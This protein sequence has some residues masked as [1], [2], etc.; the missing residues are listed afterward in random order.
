MWHKIESQLTATPLNRGRAAF[1]SKACA[2]LWR[3]AS[4][5]RSPEIYHRSTN[6]TESEAKRTICWGGVRMRTAL[7]EDRFKLILSAYFTVLLEASL[8]SAA[9][10]SGCE[11]IWKTSSMSSKPMRSAS[12]EDKSPDLARTSSNG[13]HISLKF[14][15]LKKTNQ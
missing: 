14:G 5:D 10:S 2:I 8:T 1:F 15:R 3:A 4:G 13:W 7:V 9:T 12:S 11:D 6:D